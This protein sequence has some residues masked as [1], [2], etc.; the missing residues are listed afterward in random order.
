MGR[1]AIVYDRCQ[2]R[3]DHPIGILANVGIPEPKHA[4]TQRRQKCCSPFITCGFGV[5]TAI[6]LDRKF[7]TPAREIEDV[8][9]D[10]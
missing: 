7:C 1:P 10:R 9:A 8:G 4:P 5:L 2:D 3:L 6:D